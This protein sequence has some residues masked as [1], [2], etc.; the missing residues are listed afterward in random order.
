MDAIVPQST[1]TSLAT[2]LCPNAAGGG[3]ADGVFKKQWAG[4]LFA[5]GA[6]GFGNAG[7]G[8][9]AGRGGG[10]SGSGA[11][12]SGSGASASGAS[13]PGSRP[14]TAAPLANAAPQAARRG[15]FRPR[16]WPTVQRVAT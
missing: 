13:A 7:Q 11:S 12:A 2:A 14:A 10:A 16:V 15:R 5:Q 8:S 1:W 6:V 3:P 9:N 4:L